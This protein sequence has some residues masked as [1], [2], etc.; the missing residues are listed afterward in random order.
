MSLCM[1]RRLI[2]AFVR[3][4]PHSHAAMQFPSRAYRMGPDASA[5]SATINKLSGCQG[6][7]M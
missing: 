3:T 5:C 6:L 4:R 2:F 1:V 7:A